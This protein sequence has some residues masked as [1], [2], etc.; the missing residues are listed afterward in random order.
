MRLYQSAFT[1]STSV[2]SAH[3]ACTYGTLYF[4]LREFR[5]LQNPIC[6]KFDFNEAI[7]LAEKKFDALLKDYRVLSV[8]SFGSVLALTLGVSASINQYTI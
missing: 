6:Q 3:L 8:P 1:G 2:S 7:S 4:I 5:Y